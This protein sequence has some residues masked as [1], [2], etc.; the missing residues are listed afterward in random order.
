MTTSRENDF[1]KIQGRFRTRLSLS[2]A[3]VDEVIQSRLLSKTL[4]ATMRGTLDNVV[5]LFVDQIDMDRLALRARVEE[6]LQ[7]LEGQTLLRRN[8]EGF[9]FLT[10]EEREISRDIKNVDLL[11]ADDAKAT[12]GR[13]SSPRRPM[14]RSAPDSPG[15]T[16]PV[17]R[18]PGLPVLKQT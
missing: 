5:T 14:V 18:R 10:N 16:K 17:V 13:S 8:G 1:S 6:S 12:R 2:S 7:R 15:T 3:N 11:A 9:F 4:D